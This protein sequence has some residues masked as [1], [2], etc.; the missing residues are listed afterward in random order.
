MMGN[1]D[2]RLNDAFATVRKRADAKE[3]S[4]PGVTLYTVP[5]GTGLRPGDSRQ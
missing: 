2:Y 3:Q 5:Y 4:T 1:T